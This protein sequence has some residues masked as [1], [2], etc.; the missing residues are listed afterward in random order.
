MVGGESALG[1]RV[2][3]KKEGRGGAAS[4]LGG[5]AEPGG[6]CWDVESG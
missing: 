4:G 5:Y 2:V 3:V 1:A 6:N